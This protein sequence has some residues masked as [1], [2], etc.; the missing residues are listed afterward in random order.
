[1]PLPLDEH[2]L[3]LHV[4]GVDVR[5]I[6]ASNKSSHRSSAFSNRRIVTLPT[7]D[8]YIVMHLAHRMLY[9]D[10]PAHLEDAI[11]VVQN[12]LIDPTVGL[13]SDG[14]LGKI[15]N[16]NEN[17]KNKDIASVRRRLAE[18]V[19]QRKT[20]RQSRTESKT[21]KTSKI[22][23]VFKREDGKGY[24][25]ALNPSERGDSGHTLLFDIKE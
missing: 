9:S 22:V 16:E 6:V 24:D 17:E 11:R 15:A 20:Q 14:T 1:M 18:A 21:S 5:S 23:I 2:S 7:V 19:A 8:V 25:L 3:A 10:A 4:K 12:A 13:P